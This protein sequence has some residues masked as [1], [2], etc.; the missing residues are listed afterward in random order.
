M[1]ERIPDGAAA[2]MNRRT[3]LR[4]LTESTGRRE[5]R[6]LPRFIPADRLAKKQLLHFSIVTLV[7]SALVIIWF[8]EFPS[9]MWSDVLLAIL[10]WILVGGFE[11]SLGYHRYFT[12]GS[13]TA[14]PVLQAALAAA[15]SMAGQGPVTYWVAIHR[16]HH[17]HSD[18]SGDPHSP[19]SE[20]AS[21]PWYKRWSA[22][23]HGHV[24]WVL[25]HDV[26]SPLHFAR[27]V[28]RNPIVRFFDRTYWFWGI[29]GI[30]L[31]GAISGAGP[32]GD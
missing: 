27:D 1:S 7:P 18:A 3:A 2:G 11:I 9:F 8:F 21:P 24:G 20:L 10:M 12:H 32:H 22:F 17:Q 31:P 16:C 26:P 28:A 15:G 29:A 4:V 14:H 30:A 19:V 5:R 6:D 25:R 23:L 13:F